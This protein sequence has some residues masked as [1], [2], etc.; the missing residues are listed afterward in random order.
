MGCF[1]QR[2]I[3]RATI[4][5]QW[6]NIIAV[7]K[8]PQT[9]KLNVETWIYHSPIAGGIVYFFSKAMGMVRKSGIVERLLQ[10]ELAL[11]IPIS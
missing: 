5:N 6:V 7:G 10:C 9:G 11:L 3:F 8:F 2:Y 1:S 4:V